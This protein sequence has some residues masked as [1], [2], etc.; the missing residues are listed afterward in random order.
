M[1]VETLK[2]ILDNYNGNFSQ[3]YPFVKNKL[4]K[5]NYKDC[6]LPF[7]GEFLFFEDIYISIVLY[8]I[9]H[10]YTNLVVVDVGCQLG[11][12]S[13]LFKQFD[14]KYIGIE[15]YKYNFFNNDVFD[16][17][18]GDF[19]DINIDLK[20]KIIISSMSLG[21]FYYNESNKKEKI[22]LEIDKLKT[23]KMLFIKS[24]NEYTNLVSKSFNRKE[25]LATKMQNNLYL[26]QNT[27]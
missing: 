21:Y 16:Y 19:I 17:F 6:E 25:I 27:L 23:S 20:N 5:Y 4:L 10:N 9:K 7:P 1:N 13:E 22:I 18:V 24:N 15:Y 11:I 3:I 12:Q 2:N 8:L 14:I 26:F